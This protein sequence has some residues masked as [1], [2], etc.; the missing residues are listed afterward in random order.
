[1][2]YA[3]ILAG[4]K[5]E[6][7]WPKSRK[8][9]PKQLLNIVDGET[10]IERTI[11]RIS[12]IVPPERL[13]I[14]GNKEIENEFRNLN[15]RIPAENYLCEPEGKNTA[16]AVGFAAFTI[17]RVDKDAVMIVLPADHIIKD[18]SSF[19]NCVEKAT[20]FAEKNYVVTFGIVPTRPETGYGYIESGSEIGKDVCMVR[21]FKEKPTHKQAN[22]FIRKK[23]FLWN[24]GI[25]VWRVDRIIQEFH[26]FQPEFAKNM[27]AYV[28]KN[29]EKRKEQNLKRIYGKTESISI[30]YAIMEKVSNVAV[31]RSSFRWDDVGSWNALE[32]LKGKDR[33][34]NTTT[35][36]TIL[37]D[38]KNSIVIS[39]DGLI[40][41]VGVSDFVIVHTKDATLVIPKGRTQ[42]VKEI[43]RRLRKRKGLKKYT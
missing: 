40:A 41:A 2:L 19:L 6:R 3:V 26:K 13:F 5:G 34:G 10:M 14:V 11:E 20:E 28:E 36:D 25:F 17:Q 4:G 37:M 43:V 30:D 38:T 1:V 27:E 24:C 32:R 18:V 21:K 35:G 16:P 42:E 12:P 39:N 8:S 22:D 9:Y 23:R 7:F 29:K 15:I 31:I 33:E